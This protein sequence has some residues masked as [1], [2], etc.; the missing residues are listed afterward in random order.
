MI[1]CLL[2]TIRIIKRSKR[3]DRDNK[4]EQPEN[5]KRLH[6]I[7]VNQNLPAKK[8]YDRLRRNTKLKYEVLDSLMKEQ[9]HL[10]AYCM[11]RI[12]ETDLP[13]KD[14][15]GVTIEHWYPK[16][17]NEE[18]RYQ[19]TDYNNLLAVCSGNI[20][21]A[22][23][24]DESDLIC[25][26]QKGEAVITVNPLDKETL[27]TI[28]YNDDGKIL[29]S[30]PEIHKDLTETLNLNYNGD[31]V[32]LVDNRKQVLVQFQF[33]LLSELQDKSSE[34]KITL[35]QKYLKHY[36]EYQENKPPYCGII[37]WWLQEYIKKL[38]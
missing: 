29:S 20:R 23:E 14:I 37:I 30:S 25:D 2:P 11:R 17:I 19:G 3:Y 5:L 36:K 16:G 22:N 32:P 35:C 4:R 21:P 31:A 12:P 24:N 7:E 8:A 34:E 9:G 26:H 10:C 28:Y 15:K 13:S 38:A 18:G 27:K 6:D 33:I 1:Y